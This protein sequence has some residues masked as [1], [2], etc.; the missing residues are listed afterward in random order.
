[1]TATNGWHCLR[2][3][4][5]ASSEE[6]KG[7]LSAQACCIDVLEKGNHVAYYRMEGSGFQ[8]GLCDRDRGGLAESAI[9]TSQALHT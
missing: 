6:P 3:G 9:D 8:R 1:M 2:P 4:Q 5:E 7:S